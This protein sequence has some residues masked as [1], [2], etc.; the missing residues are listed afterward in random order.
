M[1]KVREVHVYKKLLILA[2]TQTQK[3]WLKNTLFKM[4]RI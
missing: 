2:N 1:S 3:L 4:L